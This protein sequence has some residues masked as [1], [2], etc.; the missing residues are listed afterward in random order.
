MICDA[1]VVEDGQRDLRDVQQLAESRNNLW[2]PIETCLECEFAKQIRQV[3]FPDCLADMGN[4]RYLED[5]QMMTSEA[6][7]D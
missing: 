1:W 3:L 6:V 7:F 4:A 5:I 2:Q